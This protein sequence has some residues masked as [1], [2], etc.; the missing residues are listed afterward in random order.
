MTVL[1]NISKTAVHFSVYLLSIIILL[2][3]CVVNTVAKNIYEIQTQLEPD[4]VT[5]FNS[6]KLYQYHQTV[7]PTVGNEN[8]IVCEEVQQSGIG[9]T[10]IDSEE[11]NTIGKYSALFLEIIT[12]LT[13][14]CSALNT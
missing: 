6:P 3:V 13:D 4:T 8:V 10:C 9:G 12:G 11:D 14:R 1:Y 7:E 5:F 2:F